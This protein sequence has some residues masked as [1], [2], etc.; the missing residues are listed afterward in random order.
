M[1]EQKA[2]ETEKN[3]AEEKNLAESESTLS[4]EDV[5][6]AVK[7]MAE[8]KPTQLLEVMAMGMSSIGHPLHNKMTGEHISKV[9]DLTS[10][11]D[12]REY[13]LNKISHANDL[14]ENRSNRRYLFAAFIIFVGLMVLVLFLFRDKTDVLIPILTGLGGLAAGFLGGWGF[15]RKSN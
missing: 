3:K 4:G 9:L 13:E 8:H 1:N 10:K 7:K 12:E 5:Q 2:P 15:G 14:S 11:H 6:Q